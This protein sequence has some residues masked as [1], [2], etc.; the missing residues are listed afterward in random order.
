MLEFSKIRLSLLATLC[1]AVAVSPSAAGAQEP[2]A[3]PRT[4]VR[5]VAIRDR[6]GQ[7]IP[8]AVLTVKSGVNRV[9]D[10]NG[11]VELPTPVD[12]DSVE[13]V[14]RRIGYRP[15]GEW[16]RVVEDGRFIVEMDPLPRAL[17]PRT[18]TERRDTPLARRGFYDRME[19]VRRGAT[20]AR[21]FTPEELDTRHV[22]QVSA[23]L[24]GESYVKLE[25]F[26][27]RAILTGRT[28]GCPVAVIVDG[29]RMTGMV[30][31]LY[32]RE[33]QEEVR[34]FGGGQQGT[35]RFLAS[36][37]TVDELL[38]A[39]SVAG[40]ELYPSAAAAP[41]ELQRAAGNGWCSILA[42]WS[43]DRR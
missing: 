30:E 36:R 6:G 35:A 11:I 39:Q 37:T 27:Q 16:V 32:T 10:E 42:I 29:M 31:E 8:Y 34:R 13:L 15:Y 12:A 2:A 41:I 5:E 38:S 24:A 21:F 1:V 25:R 19:R 7:A 20:V 22:N 4:P 14:V 9:A 40:M 26:N 17:N 3:A 28:P 23:L 33:G 18:I 43:G